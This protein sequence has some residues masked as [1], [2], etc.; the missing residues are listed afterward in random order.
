[1]TPLRFEAKLK[2]Q[3]RAQ[4]WGEY[5]GY[6]DLSLKDYMFMQ[7]RLLQEQLA[8]WSGS[9]L[10]QQLLRGR[11]PE[12]FEEL[13]AMLPLTSYED[14]ADTLLPKRAEALPGQPVI[15]IQTTWEGGLRP[16]KVAPYT[17]EMLDTYR[18]NLCTLT[19]LS[20]SREKGQFSV[21]RGDRVLYGGASLPYATGLMPSLLGEDI[22]FDWLPNDKQSA[23]ASF[24]QRI[25]NGFAQ[26][27]TGGID[28]F[29]G[30]GAVANFITERFAGM[31]GGGGGAHAIS[32][33]IAARYVKAK[34][35]CRRDG[36]GL[37][38]KDLFRIKGFVYTGPDSR[39][40]RDA[41]T[42][43]WGVSPIEIAAGTEST[44]IAA[45]DWNR[46]GMV[47]F[48]NACFYEFIPEAEMRRS[49]LDPDYKPRTC[50]MDE[51]TAGER[52]ELVISVF[53]GGAFMR[54]RI[55]DVYRCVSAGP[56][57]LPRFYFQDRIPTVIDIA[58]FTRI[59]EASIRQV[60]TLSKLPI[61]AWFARKEYDDQNRP[62]LHL[63][64]EIPKEEQQLAAASR[65]VL[66][67]H[68]SAYFRYFDSDYAD[69]KKLLSIEP[70]QIDILKCGV[71]A[72]FQQERGRELLR[73]NPS[74]LDV[75]EL[76]DYQKQY[77]C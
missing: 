57:E 42:D 30:M 74:A 54:Y 8:C 33:T 46:N 34:Y 39:C 14:Y 18:H 40:Y 27:L 72:A 47:F 75:N 65:Q 66:I 22:H 26:G 37:Q 60:I 73:I 38:P 9:G 67:D 41:L 64:V 4:L 51:V 36:R 29:F 71:I 5:C 61:S 24:S 2:K 3:P 35:L 68:L 21:H 59:T 43:A 1:M 7:H 44:C 76:L 56:N 45:E 15:W 23:A 32:P 55:G 70:L 16:T 62:F 53:H 48:P 17:R 28:Y 25:K 52:Y 49:L 58:G 63:F 12:N 50:L 13:R 20:T 10:G 31:G 69:L 19:M 11:R 6:L 77:R